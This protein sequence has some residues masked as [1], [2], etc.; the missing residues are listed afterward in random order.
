MKS[1]VYVYTGNGGVLLDV[2]V[3]D[4][5]WAAEAFT[6]DMQKRG[7]RTVTQLAA[8]VLP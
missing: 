2:K 7:F 3:F 8:E 4:M 1:V 5:A 6:A